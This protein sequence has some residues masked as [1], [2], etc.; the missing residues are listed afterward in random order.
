VAV[1]GRAR[2]MGFILWGVAWQREGQILRDVIVAF[3]GVVVGAFATSL[4]EHLFWRV[5][6][7]EM[8]S[9]SQR[10]E[11][12]RAQAA[13]AERLQQL[14]RQTIDLTTDLISGPH[15]DKT[16]V[17]TEAYIELLRLQRELRSVSASIRELFPDQRQQQLTN[18]STRLSQITL[19]TV[20][21]QAVDAL[22]IE[23]EHLCSD[24][25]TDMSKSQNG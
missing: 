17:T 18:F 10:Q 23:L 8:L 3:A 1:E 7:R 25:R 5:Q 11:R 22:R 4:C 6:H 24:L 9:L 13:A 15:I 21:P 14:G 16:R 20:S 12:H 19:R 2:A